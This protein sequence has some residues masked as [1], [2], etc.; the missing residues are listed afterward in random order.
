MEIITKSSQE[1]EEIGRIFAEKLLEKK[2]KAVVALFGDLGAGKT[3]FTKGFAKGLGVSEE[4]NSPTFLIYKKYKGKMGINFY[5][6]DAYRIGE[7]DLESI[8]FEEKLKEKSSVIIIEWSENIKKNIPKDA[9]NVYFKHKSEKE[10]V[11][12]VEGS[13][14]IIPGTCL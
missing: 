9:I 13:S 6:F 11:L 8:E 12:I 10:R 3:T 4:I 5:H 1:T 7:G 14:G 2:Q